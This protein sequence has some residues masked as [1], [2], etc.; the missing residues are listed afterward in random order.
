MLR[1]SAERCAVVFRFAALA[2]IAI[3]AGLSIY[4]FSSADGP[5][6]RYWGL[7]VSLGSFSALGLLILAVTDRIAGVRQH[8]SP[9]FVLATGLLILIGFAGHETWLATRLDSTPAW[10]LPFAIGASGNF[11]WLL[12]VLGLPALN[13]K[14]KD[15]GVLIGSI[16]IICS[17]A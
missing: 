5:V 16:V 15:G 12:L 3:G 8:L 1:V 11:A 17:L 2:V 6:S 13:S 14:A 10:I 4:A 9:R 7:A